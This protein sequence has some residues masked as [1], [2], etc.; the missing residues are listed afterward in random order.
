MSAAEIIQKALKAGVI[1]APDGAENIKVIGEQDV[2]ERWLSTVRE[3]KPAILAALIPGKDTADAPAV[4]RGC[5]RFEVVDILGKQIP[6]C[7]YI[8]PG[9]YFDGWRRLPVNL[10]KCL[11]GMR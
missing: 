11:Y 7:L 5:T 3:N 2:V 6:G 1:I 4:C 9:Q 10:R 8:A